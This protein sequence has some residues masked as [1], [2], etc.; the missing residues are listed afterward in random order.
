MHLFLIGTSYSYLNLPDWT[1]GNK[2]VGLTEE[3]Q[4]Q[5]AA[6]AHWLPQKYRP[7]RPSIAVPCN[8]LLKPLPP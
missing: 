1:G 4:R 8:A 7:S 5:V 3:G 2:D 6:L